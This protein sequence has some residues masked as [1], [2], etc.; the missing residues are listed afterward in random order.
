MH[1]K[2]D[3]QK[4]LYWMKKKKEHQIRSQAVVFG[5]MLAGDSSVCVTNS[6]REQITLGGG[7]LKPGIRWQTSVT[8]GPLLVPEG[9]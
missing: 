9:T 6:D 2:S 5:G 3:I 7:F 4:R 1:S 8:S